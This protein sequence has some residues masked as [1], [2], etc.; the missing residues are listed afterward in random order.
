MAHKVVFIADPG[1][2]GAFAIALALNDPNFEVLGLAATAGNI[3]AEMATR[4]IHILT[5]H[6]D[7]P[8]WPRL[9]AALPVEY[10]IDGTALHGPNGFGGL[11]L[12][13]AELH[14]RT[15]ADKLL[16]DFAR[17]HPRDL[18]VVVMGPC[19]V[20]ARAFDVAP[21]MPSLLHRIVVLGGAW[22]EPGNASAA[23]EFHFYCDPLAARRVLHCNT[24]VTLLPL[25]VMRKALFA[26]TELLELPSPHSRTSTFLRQ[27]VPFGI[28]ATASAYGIEGFHLK[29]VL[30]LIAVALP[31]AVTTRPMEVDV[32]TRGELT[33][34]MSVVDARWGRTGQPNVDLAIGVDGQAVR[35]Y[36]F[37]TLSNAF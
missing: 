15:P 11:E 6:L 7:P 28:G 33:R 16:V 8:R 24:P 5:S 1:I 2:D 27:I 19:T 26:P 31:G 13:C 34:G 14:H 30:G 36:I 20:L 4:N 10:D 37:Q 18:T 17:L 29:D 25:D 23:A 21:D 22:H 32:E 35:D 12:P 3:P 9:G